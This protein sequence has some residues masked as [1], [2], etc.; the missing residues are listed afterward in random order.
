MTFYTC[1]QNF[2]KNCKV[3]WKIQSNMTFDNFWNLNIVTQPF[4]WCKHFY[5]LSHMFYSGFLFVFLIWI[6]SMQGW[7]ANMSHGVTR[8]I[9]PQIL[10]K[11]CFRE[12]CDS[13]LSG[14]YSDVSRV[15]LDWYKYRTHTEGYIFKVCASKCS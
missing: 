7:R 6:H 1:I 4:E 13:K 2:A 9:R 14:V 3:C 12:M 15:F 10:V 11:L 5:H 8:K